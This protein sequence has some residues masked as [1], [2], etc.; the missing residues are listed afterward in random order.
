MCHDIRRYR[1]T[2]SLFGAVFHRK[3]DTPSNS[4]V[5]KI[6]QPKQFKSTAIEWEIE[7]ES[8][9]VKQYISHQY[10]Q[11]H[12]HLSVAKTGFYISQ[13][14]PYLGAS[15]DGAVY[16]PSCTTLL[17][18]F[19]E[20]KCPYKHHNDTPQEACSVSGFCCSLDA[21]GKVLIKRNHSYYAQV[22]GQMAFGD[23]QWCGFAIYTSKNISVQRIETT[24]SKNSF[25]L[26]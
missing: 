21:N 18:G 14:H 22:Q 11:G 2:A 17:F 6:L 5:L 9:A 25:Q 20:I 13:S 15:P 24:G 12:L 4:L 3:P 23:R 1:V 16:E 19:L 7:H 8:I 10:F 26:N